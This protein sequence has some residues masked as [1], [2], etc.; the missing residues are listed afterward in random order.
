M[1]RPI[2][3][4]FVI[5]CLFLAGIAVLIKVVPAGAAGGD[6]DQTFNPGGTGSSF[7]VRAVAVQPD[8]KILIGGTFPDYNGVDVPDGIM[9]L[10]P[11]GTIDTSFNPGGS[12]VN[13]DVRAIAVLPSGKIL[14][15]GAFSAYNGNNFQARIIRLNANGT[16]DSTFNSA[17]NG[18][19]GAIDAIAVQP[20]GKILIGGTFTAYNSDFGIPQRVLRLNAEGPRDSSF[21][22]GGAGANSEVRALAV[23]P[24]GK[25]LI[26]G[27]FTTYNSVDVPDSVLRLNTDGTRDPLFNSGGSGANN[28]LRALVLQPD[29]K[30]LITGLFTGYNGDAAAPDFIMRLNTDGSNDTSFNSGG[31]GG[32]GSTLS[33]AIQPDGKIL[34]GSFFLTSYNGDTN[35]PDRLMRL[36]ANGT[37]DTSFNYGQAGA[38][39]SVDVIAVQPDGK[40]LIGGDFTSYNSDAS[41]PDR[42]LRL[43]PATGTVSFSSANY[44]VAESA[45]NAT[46]TVQRTGGTDNQVVAK[47]TLTDVTT[48][49]ADYR[50]TPGALDTAFN[51]GGLGVTESSAAVDAIAVQPDGKILFGGSLMTSYN[52]DPAAPDYI[53]RLNSDGTRD[54]TFNPGGVG[55][56][57]PVLAIAV[58][59]DGKIVVGG[60]ITKYNNTSIPKHLMRL[61]ADG[62]RDTTFNN[63]GTGGND[64]VEAVA[65]QPDGKIL[66]AGRF[67]SYNS[68]SVFVLARV[69]ADGTIDTTF[70]NGGAG[71]D[72]AVDSLAVQSD[73]KIL[74]GGRFLSYN[75]DTTAQFFIRLNADGTRDTTFNSGGSGPDSGV[76]AIAVQADG[77]ILLGGNFTSY[78]GDSSAPDK[79]MRVNANG[80]RETSFNSGGGGAD[81]GVN[82]IKVQPD[83]K[84]VVSGAFTSYNGDTSAPDFIMRLNANGSRD[85]GFNSG[86]AGLNVVAFVPVLQPDGKIL[87]GGKFTGYNG[88]TSAPD[89]LIRL[90]GDFFV[91]W[92]AGD[93]TDKT[94]QLP[95]INDAINE[96]PDETLNFTLAI[97]S[98]GA[99]LGSPSTSV[100]TILDPNDAPTNTVPATQTTNEDTPRVFSSGSGNQVSIS[101]PDAGTNPVRV[102]LTATQGTVTLS[103]IS[104]LDFSGGGT[105]DGTDDAVMSFTGTLAN[106]NTALNGMTFKPAANFNGTAGL[107]ILTNDQGSTGTG[108]AQSDTDTVS[109]TVNAVNDAPVNTVPAAQSTNEDVALAFSS[110]NSNQI[111]I[112]DADAGSNP[113]RVTL[114]VTNGTLTLASLGGISF[115]GG[116]GDGTDDP[117]MSFTGTVAS[118][119][120]ALNGMSFK[121]SADFNGAASLQIVTNDQG[122]TGSGGAQSDTDTVSIT[123]N[124]VNDAPVNTVPAAQSTNEDVAFAFSSA[125]SNQISIADPDAGSNPVRVTLT[126]ING[127]VTVASLG[128]ISFA[129][130]TGDGSDDPLMSFTGT[131]TSINGA[132]NGMTFKPGADFN[133][134]S[135]LQIVTNDQG[136]TGSGGAQSDTDTVSITVNAVNDAPSFNKGADIN[137]PANSPA[138]TVSPWAANMSAGP[139]NESNQTVDFI[140]SNN[141]N[142]LFSVQPAISAN[143]T[144]TFTAAT[145]QVGQAIV[146]VKLHDNGGTANGGVDTSAVQTFVINVFG[147][148]AFS[149]SLYTVAERGGSV[150][151]TVRRIG[152]T[153]QP[154]SID[155]ATDDGSVPTVALPCA[156]AN[157]AALERCDYERA[158]GTFKFAAGETQKTF[159]VLINDDSYIEGPETTTLHLF[160]PVGTNNAFPSN[161]TLQ[162]TDDATES[163]GNV[164]DDDQTFVAQHYRDFLNREPDTDGLKFWVDSIK[165]CGNDQPCRNLKRN[166][167]SVAFFV[168][169]EFQQTGFLVER[170]HKAAFG[171]G[172]GSSTNGGAHQMSVPIVRFVTFLRDTQQIG[173][174]PNR[175]IVGQANWQ[176][177]LETNK[178]A[179]SLDFVQRQEFLVRYPAQTSASAFVNLL[180]ANAGGVLTDAEKS[181]LVTELTPNPSDASLR[182]DVVRKVAENSTFQNKE[183]N[184]AF[185]LMQYFGYLR[186]N[187][188]DAPD[189]NYTGYDFWLTKLNQFG[190]FVRAEMVK[191]F[192]TSDEYRKR[193]GQ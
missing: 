175:V 149:Q 132:L 117:L 46:I 3:N 26:G 7:N 146:S 151:V 74:I 126:A 135:S 171:D 189:N 47:V 140:V 1:S 192:I 156:T 76:S 78:N 70:N 147:G 108:G 39:G 128:G 80:S 59:P 67:N 5:A 98:G 82:G 31:S 185:V 163:A 182:A 36:N 172:T 118:I 157:G 174:T 145:D 12:G 190:D 88:D 104:G 134:V 24:D 138:L 95:I 166:N 153:S 13:V 91:T 177:Q 112:A 21:N 106:I 150:T 38:S 81:V 75:G 96:F 170:M 4:L 165:A 20:D 122:N 83:G 99:N 90:E 27:D 113:V 124:A 57:G 84:I 40:I 105:G 41:V 158:T 89:R 77:K 69:N 141:N 52:D 144:L 17:G 116:T 14:I 64:A 186:R 155:Y 101:D 37:L 93:A 85:T 34:I 107:Q 191:A 54:T 159:T 180:D 176:Q 58:Q 65:L 23:Q 72:Q 56:N 45:G 29:G 86:G 193:F 109:I 162:I 97:M 60:E 15:G 115:A 87:V 125:N 8:G 111:S 154:A 139:A 63:G 28:T 11:D 181:A 33:M 114:T 51:S 25:I 2:Q 152:D 183:F 173:N 131:V 164:I 61:N 119:N 48:S 161:A 160:N 102:T 130:G 110:A 179:F 6:I 9:R 168:S 22:P 100:L 43:L 73:G 55:A 35:A 169:I 121:P 103:G 18:S 94:I 120:V 10:N 32:N 133:G 79:I 127:T 71:P 62:T 167:A 50:F 30:I 184:R 68:S 92:P 187:P 123:V 16:K 136:N 53:M 143:G 44:S 129:G 188:D 49:P 42:I 66:I 142:S 178:Q 19:N 137:L 148:F